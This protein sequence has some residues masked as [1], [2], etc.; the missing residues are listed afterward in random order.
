MERTWKNIAKVLNFIEQKNR[1]YFRKNLKMKHLDFQK[2]SILP[3]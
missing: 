3:V 2:N 1:T